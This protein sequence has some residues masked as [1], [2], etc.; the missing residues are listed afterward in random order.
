MS[1]NI[2]DMKR[3]IICLI[4]LLVTSA[5]AAALFDNTTDANA[6]VSSSNRSS[7][8]KLE[9]QGVLVTQLG[10]RLKIVLGVDNFFKFPTSTQLLDDRSATLQQVAGLLRNYG[11]QLIT[12][13]GHTDNV[14]SDQAKLKRS[15]DQAN[16]IAA[17]LWSKGIPLN[18]MLVIGCGDTEPV[19]SNHM[20]EDVI[21]T[22]GS[23]SNRRIEIEVN[24]P[25]DLTKSLLGS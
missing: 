8:A 10:G 25:P 5:C 15:Y 3:I 24:Y 7:G 16:T 6:S 14:G 21:P 4:T 18:H 19:G 22:G 12:I 2:C 9:K 23:A 1:V 20:M 17:Y 11:S 13:S